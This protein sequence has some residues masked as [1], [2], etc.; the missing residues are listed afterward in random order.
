MKKF[1]FVALLSVTL[2]RVVSF[3]YEDT[4]L[5]R[6]NTVAYILKVTRTL[7]QQFLQHKNIKTLQSQTLIIT[8]TVNIDDFT[9]TLPITRQIDENMLYQLSHAGFH[10]IDL[11]AMKILGAQDI[12]SDLVLVSTY[13]RYRYEM[14]INAR[15]IK[16]KTGVVMASAQVRVPRRVFK[17]VEKLYNKNSWFAPQ[18]NEMKR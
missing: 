15:I 11:H 9:T 3:A 2:L 12:T 16:R 1:F 7:T 8:P 5:Y 17:S 10:V 18:K 4:Q 6:D 14:V 13:T